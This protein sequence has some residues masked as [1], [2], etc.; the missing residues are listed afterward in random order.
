MSVPSRQ[1]AGQRVVGAAHRPMGWPRGHGAVAVGH[2]KAQPSVKWR[3]SGPDAGDRGVTGLLLAT[4]PS[5]SVILVTGTQVPRPPARRQ[6]A[7]PSSPCS[8]HNG[9][10]AE[11]VSF[12][13]EQSLC[14]KNQG[15]FL[16]P[17]GSLRRSFYFQ[18]SLWWCSLWV[19][20][21]PGAARRAAPGPGCSLPWAAGPSYTDCLPPTCA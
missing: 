5:P 8:P 20:S 18:M 1:P 15:L 6:R 17:R 9:P 13:P 21:L 10:Q 16:L 14:Q 11:Q 2:P 3:R 19:A 7:T 4:S 12:A